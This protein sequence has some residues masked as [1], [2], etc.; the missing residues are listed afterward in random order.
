VDSIQQQQFDFDPDSDFTTPPIAFVPSHLHISSYLTMSA[1][2]IPP[3]R[4]IA[5]V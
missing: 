2:A 4:H 1:I 5:D 3:Y